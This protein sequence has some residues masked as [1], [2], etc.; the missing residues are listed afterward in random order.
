MAITR[1]FWLVW[2]INKTVP[3]F[4]HPSEQSAHTEAERLA[5]MFPGEQF[6]VLES[7]AAITRTDI[8][9]VNLRPDSIPF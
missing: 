9:T 8:A 1:P 5:R 4:Q 6:V 3:T 2:G 7:V